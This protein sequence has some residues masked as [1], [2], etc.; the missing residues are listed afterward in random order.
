MSTPPSS[1]PAATASSDAGLPALERLRG[2]IEAAAAEIER[3]RSANAAL[4]DRVQELAAA[5]VARTDGDALPTL[6]LEGDPAEL[7]KK[8]ESFIE[9]ID[10]ML[11]E[12]AT[13]D[14]PAET[15]A[16]EANGEPSPESAG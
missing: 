7:R 1:D 15:E 16:A 14:T 11:A 10:R 5:D 2:R 12:P 8:V 9:A 13:R 3:L 4:S 6:T